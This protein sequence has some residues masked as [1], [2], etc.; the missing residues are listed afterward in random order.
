M[1]ED[2][3]TQ[4]LSDQTTGKD[5]PPCDHKQ[6]GSSTVEL[7]IGIAV[8]VLIVAI[9]CGVIHASIERAE[10]CRLARESAREASVG[11]HIDDPGT[12]V[13]Y[14]N[15]WITVSVQRPV[16]FLI[17]RGKTVSCAV[18]TMKEDGYQ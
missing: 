9:A 14:E 5:A 1:I 3:R 10:T 4:R 13:T 12:H 7:S 16:S 11:A 6:A 8:L 18:K 17:F 15:Q 2:E